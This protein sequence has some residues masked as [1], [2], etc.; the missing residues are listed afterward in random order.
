[1]NNSW[2]LANS[3]YNCM[4]N[5]PSGVKA[6]VREFKHLARKGAGV[7][8]NYD[9]LIGIITS[10]LK[11]DRTY[12]GRRGRFDDVR[13]FVIDGTRMVIQDPSPQS[14]KCWFDEARGEEV[15]KCCAQGKDPEPIGL[16]DAVRI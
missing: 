5:H 9:D 16:S 4:S 6:V 10:A 3:R 13:R 1:M 12:C 7:I 2:S 15:L 8:G 14:V 11:G